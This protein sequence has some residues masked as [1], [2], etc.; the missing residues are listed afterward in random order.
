MALAFRG[1]LIHCVDHFGFPTYLLDGYSSP[2]TDSVE[3][4]TK[5]SKITMFQIGKGN[6][7]HELKIFKVYFSSLML[8]CASKPG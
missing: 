3:K 6:L 1:V 5:F 4:N 7:A 2:C 8:L